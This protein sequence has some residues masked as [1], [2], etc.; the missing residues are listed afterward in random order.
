MKIF[1]TFLSPA[2]NLLQ[3]AN[4]NLVQ[5]IEPLA[6][7]QAVISKP[8]Y[9]RA[10]S[11]LKRQGKCPLDVEYRRINYRHDVIEGDDGKLKW[12]ISAALRCDPNP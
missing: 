7:N 5:S 10:L 3:V 2:K 9:C 1:T 12:T 4:A 6:F 11:K 8:L